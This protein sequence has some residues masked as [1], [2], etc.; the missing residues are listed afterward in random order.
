MIANDS[1]EPRRW[2]GRV[3]LTSRRDVKVSKPEDFGLWIKLLFKL[4]EL[5]MWLLSRAMDRWQMRQFTRELE[6]QRAEW[7]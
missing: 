1:G 2:R 6:R 5:N 7:N 3:A 4:D